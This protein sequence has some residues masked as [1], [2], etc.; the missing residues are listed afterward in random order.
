ML[1][2]DG[3]PDRLCSFWGLITQSEQIWIIWCLMCP[4]EQIM[5]FFPHPWCHPNENG[6]IWNICPNLRGHPW[7]GK[8]G[9]KVRRKVRRFVRRTANQPDRF[10]D[11]FKTRWMS[12]HATKV[13]NNQYVTVL[14][15]VRYNFNGWCMYLYI[16]ESIS[17]YR[18][19]GEFV[20]L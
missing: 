1:A 14:S 4:S 13:I 18:G 3:C 5:H 19:F 2:D 7:I 8:Y 12:R 16:G 9:A 6:N 17:H 15:A 10:L 11:K 20:V